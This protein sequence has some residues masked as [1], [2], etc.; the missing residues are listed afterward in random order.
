MLSR[1]GACRY[2]QS[3]DGW[4]ST[5][6]V[7]E[8]QP[9]ELWCKSRS[10]LH[11]KMMP[12]KVVDENS[13]HGEFFVSKIFLYLG[14]FRIP[15]VLLEPTTCWLLHPH[16]RAIIPPH[17]PPWIAWATAQWEQAHLSNELRCRLWSQGSPDSPQGN[18]FR[19]SLPKLSGST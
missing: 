18:L 1:W 11:S 4:I 9:P 14:I 17:Y 10:W 2:I 7:C 6:P 12:Q 19:G 16:A 15:I 3:A 5:L 13:A 8:I